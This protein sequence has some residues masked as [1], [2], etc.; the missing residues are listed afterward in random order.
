MTDIE[1]LL[2][3]A[4]GCVS[5]ARLMDDTVV[6][7]QWE[8]PAGSSGE[9]AAFDYIESRMKEAGFLTE[10]ILHDAYI[11]L[12]GK[13]ELEA[14]GKGM[15]CIT[16]SFGNCSPKEGLTGDV[17]WCGKGSVFELAKA[18]VQGK[19]AL[20]EGLASPWVSK[21]AGD[22]G[23]IGQIHISPDGE[24]HEMCVSPVWGNPS[25][26]D[27]EA[28]PKTAIVTVSR[29]EGLVLRKAVQAG[30]VSATIKAEVD[31]GWRRTPLLVADLVPDHLS[32]D[33]PFVMFSGHV[34]TWHIGAMD[35]GTANATMLEV[36]RALAAM[37][38]HMQR[39]VRMCFWSG[40]SQ[41]RYSSS[42]WYADRYF[43]ELDSRCIAHVNIDSTGGAGATDLSGAGSDLPLR[44]LAAEAVELVS[45]QTI[46]G[47]KIGRAGDESFWGIGIPAVFGAIS[48][49]VAGDGVDQ[50]VLPLGWWW[51]TPEDTVDK[52]DPK[53]L[54]RDSK[55]FVYGLLKLVLTKI[56]PLDLAGTLRALG[57]EVGTLDTAG[58]R[59]DT[60]GIKMLAV[61]L[62]NDLEAAMQSLSA[63]VS[64]ELL[65]LLSRILVP[66]ECARMDRFNHDPALPVSHWPV[67]DPIRSLDAAEPGSDLARFAEVGAV[68]AINR[69]RYALADVQTAIT[70]AS[71]GK[72][73]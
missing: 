71:E 60:H 69:I 36:S 13:A 20:I 32:D 55:V 38:G 12:P 61:K 31:T 73:K 30:P 6:L 11:S 53:L 47:R 65:R 64:N 66:L 14:L 21:L 57:E 9:A 15:K 43:A 52:I 54:L 58:T 26:E 39:A 10:R 42:A 16:H 63:D 4:Q 46:K 45:G 49:Q 62:A 8:K 29:K 28:L 1:L 34:D 3:Q 35:N 18:G 48:H 25:I 72:I 40:H 41:G 51:H 19:I 33:A 17:V 22:H 5:E 27:L 2:Q 23:A 37:K 56:L 50:H 68:R 44:P 59:V 7:A 24:I 70:S 67:L